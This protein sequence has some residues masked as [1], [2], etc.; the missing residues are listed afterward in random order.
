MSKVILECI[1]VKSKLR[2][3]F[4][5]FI[6][7]DGEYFSNAYDN[8]LNCSFPKAIRKEGRL[9]EI[10]NTDIRI[11]S[12]RTG[13]YYIIKKKNIIIIDDT[14]DADLI[15]NTK[16]FNCDECVICIDAK[17]TCLFIPCGHLCTCMECCEDIEATCPLCRTHIDKKLNYDV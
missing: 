12:R 11:S 5:H 14:T 13:H 2:I 1:K 4:K 6:N 15:K 17:S 9:Y 10:P 16:V 3:R 8:T 7:T